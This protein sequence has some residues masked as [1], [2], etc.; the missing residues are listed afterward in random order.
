MVAQILAIRETQKERS[1]TPENSSKTALLYWRSPQSKKIMS[2]DSTASDEGCL[3]ST[4]DVVKETPVNPVNKVT[5]ATKCG[6][7][8][9][10]GHNARTCPQRNPNGKFQ[11]FCND[12]ITV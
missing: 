9:E 11:Q 10:Y 8:K 6:I 4:M 5:K 3:S 2:D 7:C 12:V 1:K